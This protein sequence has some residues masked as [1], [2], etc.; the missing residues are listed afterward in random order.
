MQ[1][2]FIKRSVSRRVKPMAYNS[3]NN[4]IE[5]HNVS[6]VKEVKTE[7]K[8]IK[9]EEDMEAI[10]K[11]KKAVGSN[12]KVPSRKVKK[13]KKEKGLIERTEESTILIT[14]DNKMLLND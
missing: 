7:E 6:E 14:E 8:E 5:N 2:F 4:R 10:E 11:L 12:A 1:R 3:V 13:E 9:K